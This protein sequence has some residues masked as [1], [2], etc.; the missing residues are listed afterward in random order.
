MPGLQNPYGAVPEA[1]NN[2]RLSLRDIMQDY[3]ANKVT[4]SNLEIAKAKTEVDRGA[5]EANLEQARMSNTR[6]LAGL[7]QREYQFDQNL[8]QTAE[9]FR[10]NH[11]LNTEK[12]QA[13]KSAQ[14]RQIKIME[15]ENARKN[16]EEARMNE[17]R[18]IGD[19]ATRAGLGR[20]V[21]DMNGLDPNMKMSRRDA[22]QALESWQIMVK[23]HPA[24]GFMAHGYNLKSDLQDLQAK[25]SDPNLAAADK[26]ALQKT[27]DKKFKQ[28]Q[29][30]D[31]FIMKEKMP[32]QAKIADTARKTYSENPNL[33]T[34]YPNYESYLQAFTKDLQQ[35]RS[36]FQ[37]DIESLKQKSMEISKPTDF[38]ARLATATSQI[39]QVSKDK[40]WNDRIAAGVNQ[41]IQAGQWNDALSYAE[42][43]LRQIL[44]KN[45]K[46]GSAVTTAAS[47]IVPTSARTYRTT[48][49]DSNAVDFSGG[50]GAIAGRLQTGQFGLNDVAAYLARQAQ[51]ARISR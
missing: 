29:Y 34:I 28:F 1:M 2:T 30:L 39:A 51:N 8:N 17:V 31:D 6:D 36:I 46:P 47:V 35:T 49:P 9:Q 38:N 18:T 23:S 3:L 50:P 33:Q 11:Q 21:L 24:M 10:Q 20:G 42:G 26:E 12:F 15:A 41:R 7:A 40:A 16:R 27:Y 37:G 45:K 22:A 5:I 43:H 25:L 14:D 19:W 44:N 32:D 13:D 4:E 48:G